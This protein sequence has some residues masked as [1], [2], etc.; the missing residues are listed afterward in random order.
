MAKERVH[1]MTI[2]NISLRTFSNTK[3]SLKGLRGFATI[4]LDDCLEIS[5]IAIAETRDGRL[6]VRFPTAPNKKEPQHRFALVRPLNRECQS[7]IQDAILNAYESSVS[8]T[9][10]ARYE[11][12]IASE[13]IM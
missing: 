6:T 5:S 8:N 11:N 10:V 7:S 2:T 9:E 3:Q 4:I 13:D 12:E 1:F